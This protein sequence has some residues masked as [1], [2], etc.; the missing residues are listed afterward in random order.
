V[1]GLFDIASVPAFVHA[2]VQR[3]GA[4]SDVRLAPGERDELVSEAVVALYELAARYEH[5]R[6]GYPQP[7]SFARYAAR[8]LP[9]KL[10]TAW[11]RLHP[12]HVYVNRGGRREWR[13]LSPAL[14]LDALAERSP[15][16][17]ASARP[18]VAPSQLR[19]PPA[20]QLTLC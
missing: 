12:E 18:I 1:T 14:S 4:I 5:H 20:G 11:H 16:L 8:F 3:W 10:T 7:G 17:L 2:T 13:Y 9:G 19:R 6:P 15:A